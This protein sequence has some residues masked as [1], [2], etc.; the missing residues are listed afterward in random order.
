MACK[1]DLKD[2]EV[3]KK[4]KDVGLYVTGNKI[5]NI[6]RHHIDIGNFRRECGV[7]LKFE[8]GV[9]D[10]IENIIEQEGIGSVR[11]FYSVDRPCFSIPRADL[12]R[13]V[14][15]IKRNGINVFIIE[16]IKGFRERYYR[17]SDEPLVYEYPLEYWMYSEIT[18]YNPVCAV[19]VVVAEYRNEVEKMKII[20][21]VEIKFSGIRYIVN[22]KFVIIFR[23]D[24]VDFDPVLLMK[25][26]LMTML[27]KLR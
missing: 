4:I 9:S 10:F 12:L 22:D 13:V 17:P 16:V 24:D 1:L 25:S 26:E 2:F 11:I 27:T 23:E 15:E 6:K 20:G 21:L 14:Q 3:L 7:S 18:L 5:G 8:E 19:P